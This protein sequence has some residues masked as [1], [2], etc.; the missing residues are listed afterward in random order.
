MQQKTLKEKCHKRHCKTDLNTFQ[1]KFENIVIFPDF[2]NY[3]VVMYVNDLVLTKLYIPTS[4]REIG[5]MFP[6]YSQIIPTK[7]CMYR[8]KHTKKIKRQVLIKC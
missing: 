5:M 1:N 4:F 8:R 2:D 3:P 6:T 7:L